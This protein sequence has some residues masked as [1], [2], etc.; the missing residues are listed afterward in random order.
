MRNGTLLAYSRLSRKARTLTSRTPSMKSRR[1]IFLLWIP[2][3]PTSAVSPPPLQSPPLSRM[4]QRPSFTKRHLRR[5]S[6]H[7]PLRQ[8]S[9]SRHNPAFSICPRSR[10]QPIST[11]TLLRPRTRAISILPNSSRH[12]PLA[13]RAQTTWLP[14]QMPL[15]H[16][17][18]M[19][20]LR[21]SR[22][23]V[24]QMLRHLGNRPKQPLRMSPNH[25]RRRNPSSSNPRRLRT[26][27]KP[28][29]FPSPTTHGRR[30]VR[31]RTR[32]TC[33]RRRSMRSG[34]FPP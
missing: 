13:K 8:A 22:L 4:T 28:L 14:Q 31:R 11:Q 32:W 33:P 24:Q 1:K 21:R 18:P 34:R 16:R 10:Q 6:Q 26:S 7:R 5:P 3:T 19:P 25:L 17:L 27:P 20:H 29:R 30:V 12:R 2:T 15:R 9:P 23:S